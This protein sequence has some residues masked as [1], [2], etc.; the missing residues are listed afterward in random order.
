M[1]DQISIGVSENDPNDEPAGPGAGWSS[2]RKG[3]RPVKDTQAGNKPRSEVL[4]DQIS[5]GVRENDPN[6]EPAGPAP[7]HRRFAKGAGR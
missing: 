4:E 7:A 5:I 2:G 3:R 6:D 1:Q